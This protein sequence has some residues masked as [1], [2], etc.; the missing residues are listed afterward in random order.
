MTSDADT[1]DQFLVRLI[2]SIEHNDMEGM[3][4]KY[5]PVEDLPPDESE[6]GN[7]D[8]DSEIDETPLEGE[9]PKAA[10]EALELEHLLA[11]L[12]EQE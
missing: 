9:D 2:N 6:T 1:R 8:L 3:K 12:D 11:G 10:Q 5:A 7:P 4:K